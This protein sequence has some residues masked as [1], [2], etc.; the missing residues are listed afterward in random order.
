MKLNERLSVAKATGG[1]VGGFIA[2]LSIIAGIGLMIAAPFAIGITTYTL[3]TSVAHGVAGAITGGVLGFGAA[4]ITSPLCVYAGIGVMGVGSAVGGIIG[5]AVSG[6]VKLAS[7]GVK[8]LGKLIGIKPASRASAP[9]APAQQ[10]SGTSFKSVTSKPAFE[11]AQQSQ[12]TFELQSV[13][14]KHMKNEATP[15]GHG[16]PK[17]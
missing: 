6:V 11:K 15:R 4:I 2:G 9:A 3:I 13:L 12:T 14:P 8:G 10:Q 1:A 16:A 17:Q 5:A 7:M